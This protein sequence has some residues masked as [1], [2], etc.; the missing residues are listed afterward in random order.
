MPRD[1]ASGLP[2]PLLAG[3]GLPA[4]RRK[5]AAAVGA[6][7]IA[8]IH[9][10]QLDL[11]DALRSGQFESDRTFDDETEVSPGTLFWLHHYA[12]IAAVFFN[13][14]DRA[15]E[16]L[17]RS[18]RID[19]TMDLGASAPAHMDR[20]DNCFFLALAHS[21]PTA[22]GMTPQHGTNHLIAARDRFEV[23]ARLDPDHFQSKHL[24][25]EAEAAR[26]IGDATGAQALYERAADAARKAGLTHERALAQELAGASYLEAGLPTPAQGCFQAAIACYQKWGADGK[27]AQ[28]ARRVGPAG[29]GNAVPDSQAAPCNPDLAPLIALGSFAASIVH[30]INQPLA[31]IITHADVGLRWLDRRQP[32]IAEA[33]EGLRNIG[34]AARRA[35]EIITSLRGLVQQRR[36]T[37]TPVCPADLVR[38]AIRLTA[39]DLDAHGIQVV[40]EFS[41]VQHPVLA[42][43]VQL[44]QVVLNLVTNA[45][46]AMVTTAPANRRLAIRTA[47]AEDGFVHLAIEDSGCGMSEAVRGKI[48]EPF[49]TTKSAGMG[50]GLALCRAIVRLHGGSIEV[51]SAPGQGAT[52]DLR[53]PTAPEA[54]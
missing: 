18:R 39:E 16:H 9:Q 14:D 1:G 13:Q 6:S 43:R 54:D 41:G 21:R 47:T 3:E 10:A 44:R 45:I 52:F 2:V 30:E 28:L 19:K 12:G 11:I 24:L 48:F 29:C 46:Q 15:A 50:V 53:L 25:L 49:F 5:I 26:L 23:S 35:A 27:A 8:R 42:D 38:D 33:R 36:A 32:D 51:R 34:D 31:G 7:G 37:L 40:I 22:R 20:A 17:H 4:I